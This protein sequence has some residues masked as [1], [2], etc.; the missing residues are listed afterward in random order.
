MRMMPCLGVVGCVEDGAGA[1]AQP[2]EAAGHPP[3]HVLDV[4]DADARLRHAVKEP[5]PVPGLL[6][7]LGDHLQHP[8]DKPDIGE[9]L[10]ISVPGPGYRHLTLNSVSPSYTSVLD[11]ILSR[12]PA[13]LPK[14]LKLFLKA[15]LTSQGTLADC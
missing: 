13:I 5:V 10:I 7:L 6:K 8:G 1:E 12:I 14:L 9:D 11:K 15:P 3:R 4:G 2:G